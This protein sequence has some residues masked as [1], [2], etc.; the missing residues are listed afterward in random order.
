[1]VYHSQLS[2]E[3]VQ[4]FATS[5]GKLTHWDLVRL[6]QHYIQREAAYAFDSRMRD[7]DVKFLLLLGG[8][9]TRPS[10]RP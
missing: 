7:W 4:E 10:A 3:H 2:S 6:P 1:M 5:I 9:C 8:C